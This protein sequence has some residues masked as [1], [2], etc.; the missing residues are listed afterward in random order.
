MGEMRCTFTSFLPAAHVSYI[1]VVVVARLALF[2]EV[3][4]SLAAQALR[5]PQLITRLAEGL[6]ALASPD[7][8][9]TR[10]ETD[11]QINAVFVERRLALGRDV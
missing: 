9:L 7:E 1:A 8:L 10:D 5:R 3:E 6:R 2:N 11:L 4:H